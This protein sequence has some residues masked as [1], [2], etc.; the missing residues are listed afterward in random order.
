MTEVASL[1]V[2]SRALILQIWTDL[3]HRHLYQFKT[4]VRLALASSVKE[5]EEILQKL[6]KTW[7]NPGRR[8]WKTCMIGFDGDAD[9]VV[10]SVQRNGNEICSHK[11]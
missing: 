4:G 3:Y 11:N 10:G 8:Q 6:I 7:I 9:E 5:L 1:H 2:A